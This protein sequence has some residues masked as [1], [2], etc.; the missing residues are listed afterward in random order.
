[1]LFVTEIICMSSLNIQLSDA[2]ITNLL[3]TQSR[4]FI[5]LKIKYRHRIT[6]YTRSK[7]ACIFC[8]I[9]YFDMFSNFNLNS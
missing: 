6:E 1:M 7:S 4:L 8:I 3:S 2:E 5:F 9:T